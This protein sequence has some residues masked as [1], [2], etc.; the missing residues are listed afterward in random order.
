VKQKRV[1][2]VPDNYKLTMLYNYVM[3]KENEVTAHREETD[4]QSTV[5]ILI[6]AAFWNKQKSFFIVLMRMAW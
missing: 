6:F 5:H 2:I 3:G 1:S 4:L